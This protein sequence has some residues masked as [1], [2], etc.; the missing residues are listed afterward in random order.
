MGLIKQ[1]E[2]HMCRKP[3]DGLNFQHLPCLHTKL[4]GGLCYIYIQLIDWLIDIYIQLTR[5]QP[6]TVDKT[7]TTTESIT[8]II[9]LAAKVTLKVDIWFY[10]ILW[11][12]SLLCL[13]S[14]WTSSLS[15]VS[16]DFCQLQYEASWIIRFPSTRHCLVYTVIN[17][18]S[19]S[20][21]E[22]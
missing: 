9:S 7:S 6:D 4:H 3:H 1:Q 13:T 5:H 21:A 16:Q 15:S 19:V 20:L 17:S 2:T 14:T 11:M 8:R 10:F 12:F 18:L 22:K